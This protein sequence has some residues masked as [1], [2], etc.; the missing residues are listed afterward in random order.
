[1][2]KLKARVCRSAAAKSWY[3]YEYLKTWWIFQKWERVPY[4]GKLTEKEMIESLPGYDI[5]KQDNMRIVYPD[6]RDKENRW[7]L[8]RKNNA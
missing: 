1:M 3:V 2:Q 4:G 5:L 8:R 6:H 7:H